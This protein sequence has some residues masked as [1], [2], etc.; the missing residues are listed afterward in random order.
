MTGNPL[1]ETV[2]I[3]KPKSSVFDLG[4][5]HNTSGKFGQM[6]PTLVL[7]VLPGDRIDLQC[8]QF[9]RMQ[10][11]IYPVMGAANMFTHYWYVPNRIVWEGFDDYIRGAAGAGSLPQFTIDNTL[12]AAQKKF[13]DYMGLPPFDVATAAGPRNVNALPFAAYQCIWNE[14]YR[15]Q[16]LINPFNYKLNAGINTIGNFM[17]IRKRALEKDYFTSARPD[18]QKGTAG[19]VIPLGEPALKT[20][21]SPSNEP[22]FVDSSG[23]PLGGGIVGAMGTGKIT[24]PPNP[25][26]AALD[27]N[28][29][30]EIQPTLITDLRNAF[31]LQA[32]LE[33]LSVTGNRITEWLKA[34]FGVTSMD[35]RFDRPE[36][37]GGT[38]TPIVISEVLNT[39][40]AFNPADPTEPG[41]RV[42]GD[43]A[44]HG[45]AVGGG[46]K[47]N[48]YVPEH[49]YIIGITTVLPRTM[50]MN[51]IPRHFLR[52]DPTDWFNPMFQFIGEQEVKNDEVFGYQ[53]AAGLQ[54]FGYQSRF[55]EY[56]TVMSRVS[57][58][59][60]NTG[61]DAW[62][63]G[64]NFASLPTLSQTFVECDHDDY[65]RIFA[66]QNGDDT[67]LFQV[68]HRIRARRLMS[69]YG[70][71]HL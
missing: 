19:T 4:H 39:S 20:G 66:V 58:D 2:E 59:F 37:C 67:L 7:E 44:G 14:W 54:A 3:D 69:Y 33:R 50:Y 42:Q 22:F 1:F 34:I 52:E 41:S 49:G 70:T 28:G 65:D 68:Y 6:H 10:A 11:L 29:S 71:P 63:M 48:F 18:P 9:M 31:K 26:N 57:G 25:L 47:K 36:F 46:Y 62:H 15:D 51:G 64:R 43:M 32:Y 53:G 30:L 40:G 16:D 45:V 8:D 38:K 17:D 56:K 5:A 61:Y 21:W 55:S 35:A 24:A 12:T 60:R 27:P 23:T 13:G